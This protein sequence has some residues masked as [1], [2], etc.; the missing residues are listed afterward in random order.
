MLVELNK[1][2]LISHKHCWGTDNLIVIVFMFLTLI[3][4][5]LLKALKNAV[6]QI[7]TQ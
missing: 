6:K 3:S 4:N 1:N 5:N 2:N 7:I